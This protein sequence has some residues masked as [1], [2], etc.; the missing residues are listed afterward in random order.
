LPENHHSQGCLILDGKMIAVSLENKSIFYDAKLDDFSGYDIPS[1]VTHEWSGVTLGP[2]P[3]PIYI[4]LAL[5]LS[6]MLDKIDILGELPYLIRVFI[7][8]FITAPFCYQWLENGTAIVGI[9]GIEREIKGKA[10]HENTFLARIPHI[11]KEKRHSRPL[12]RHFGHFSTNTSSSTL[13]KSEE[14]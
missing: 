3:K 2:S 4:K 8:A 6:K 9:D 10:F 7:Q 1:K 13:N 11:P 12:S 14:D 5:N